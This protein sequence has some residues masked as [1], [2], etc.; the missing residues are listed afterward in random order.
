MASEA[1]RREEQQSL[2]SH[3]CL[4]SIAWERTLMPFSSRMWSNFVCCAAVGTVRSGTGIG[5]GVKDVKSSPPNI[6]QVG[7][8]CRT[9]GTNLHQPPR[10]LPARYQGRRQPRDLYI[11]RRGEFFLNWTRW[12]CAGLVRRQPK[13]LVAQAA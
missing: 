11:P 12:R 9:H 13:V 5:V 3:L 7:M 6:V 4:G 10:T 2:L 1:G 8:V